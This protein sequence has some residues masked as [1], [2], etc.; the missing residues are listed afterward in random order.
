MQDTQL[1]EM[2]ITTI[3]CHHPEQA[4]I[5]ADTQST[6]HGDPVSLKLGSRATASALGNC[7]FAS[8]GYAMESLPRKQRLSCPHRCTYIWIVDVTVSKLGR[9]VPSHQ[10][11]NGASLTNYGA[12]TPYAFHLYHSW[13]PSDGGHLMSLAW[14]RGA[15]GKTAISKV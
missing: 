12:T 13:G 10:V 9:W 15:E 5:L 3:L 6:H 11:G 7:I 2:G 1:A 14:C 8:A 4:I